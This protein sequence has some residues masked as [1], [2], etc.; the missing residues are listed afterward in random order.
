MIYRNPTDLHMFT[1]LSSLLH[2][3]CLH[4]ECGWSCPLSVLPYPLS[5]PLLLLEPASHLQNGPQM[6]LVPFN[7]FSPLK[8]FFSFFLSFYCCSFGSLETISIVANS[9]QIKLYWTD[10]YWD[11][12]PGSHSLSKW[13]LNAIQY[14]LCVV[15]KRTNRPKLTEFVWMD[16]DYASI[17]HRWSERE[18]CLLKIITT[19]KQQPC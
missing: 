15:K 10:L 8:V 6:S 17:L 12:L 18:L 19:Q 16:T 11:S 13:H 7:G 9:I 14:Y 4:D 5:S 2:F 1:S 3:I